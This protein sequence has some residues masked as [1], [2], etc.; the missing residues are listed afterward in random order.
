MGVNMA[1]VLH[2]IAKS[3]IDQF[4][5]ELFHQQQDVMI[6][7][8]N[9]SGDGNIERNRA[10]VILGHIDCNSIAANLFVSLEHPKIKS[11]RVMMQHPGGT[12]P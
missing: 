10:A 6:Y 4:D 9:T 5:T 7:R 1:A 3:G 11:V 12:Q 2:A 8:R